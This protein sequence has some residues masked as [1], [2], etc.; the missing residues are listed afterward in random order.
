MATIYPDNLPKEI[1]DDPLRKGE[2]K[3]FEALKNSK[4]FSTCKIYYSADWINKGAKKD[5][6]RDGECD[7]I[8]TDRD[9]G[10]LF[11]EVKGGHI[12]KDENNQWYSGNQEIKNPIKQCNKNMYFFMEEYKRRWKS[13]RLGDNFPSFFHDSFAFFPD[14]DSKNN[15]YLGAAYDKNK[16]GFKK[17]LES[18]EKKILSFFDEGRKVKGLFEELGQ[19]S[20][21]IFHEMF[22]KPFNFKLSLFDEIKDNNLAISKLTTEQYEI[23]EGSH[24][25]WKNLWC[26]GPAGS[27]KTIIAIK[28]FLKEY[29]S[30]ENGKLL[31]LCRN[32]PISLKIRNKIN[33]EIN[34]KDKKSYY[35][36]TFDAFCKETL[37]NHG[38]NLDFENIEKS[39]D[40]VFDIVSNG[41]T[42]F[43]VVIIDESQ[44]FS[45]T[46]WTIL[47]N[48]KTDNTVF[49]IF[50]DSNQKIW[51][52]SRPEISQINPTSVYLTHVLRN[53]KTIAQKSLPFFDGGGH[54]LTLDGPISNK[55]ELIK[56]TNFAKTVSEI[57]KKLIFEG[58]ENQSI[59]VLTSDEASLAEFN[60]INCS[61]IFK[62]KGMEAD[63]VIFVIED[64]KRYKPEHLYVGITRA[65]TFLN[66]LCR[67]ED[68]EKIK[69]LLI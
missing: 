48:L 33:S 66:I 1:L 18:I 65:K 12:S 46:W 67:P 49:W 22:T 40:E 68:E 13:K 16:F 53:S 23:L 52:N 28:K 51:K 63:C 2:I 69:K 14:V 8:I 44:D 26:E 20:Q 64:L 56:T 7:F 38:S 15:E 3:L 5:R 31:F 60:G 30:R 11:I 25:G 55:F 34:D 10:V 58:I 6:Q 17:D 9:Y 54:E 32:K 45:P 36:G 24:R 37:S 41:K 47:E 4:L 61:S 62:Y 27:G 42:K 50:G 39:Y 21:D 29:N 35:V 43:D 57:H 59:V 19:E